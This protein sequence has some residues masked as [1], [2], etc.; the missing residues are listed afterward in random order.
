MTLYDVVYI[1]DGKLRHGLARDPVE[2]GSFPSLE[3][4]DQSG[5][6]VSVGSERGA[7]GG[8]RVSGDSKSECLRKMM[9]LIRG[10]T[11]WFHWRCGDHFKPDTLRVPN[12]LTI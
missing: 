2:G 11:L 12:T 3:L 1:I 4:L 8:V 6:L 9:K 7:G 5:Q 10:K